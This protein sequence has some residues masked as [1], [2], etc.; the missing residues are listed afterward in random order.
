[1][2]HFECD[3]TEGAHEN[4]MRRL[5]NTNLDQ[6]CGYGMDPICD[7]AREKIRIACQAPDAQV[8]FLVGGTQTNMTVIAAA[9]KPYQGV[10]CA[11]SGHINVHETG[12]IESTGHK[13]LALKSENGKI[14]A[15]AVREAV[16]AHYASGSFEHT[17]QPGMVYISHPTEV[18]T[19]YS[20]EELTALSTTCHALGLPLF[21]DGARL[22]YALECGDVTLP[23]LARLCDVFYIGGTK[24]GALFGEAVVITN[25]ALAKDFRY[26]L[27]Q[28]GGM[29]AKGRLLGIQFDEL[30]TDDLYS[31][32]C[33]EAVRKAMRLQKTVKEKGI[34]LWFESPTNQQ[35]VILTPE[36]K[37]KLS[38]QFVLEEWGET[39]DGGQ[40]TRI[41]TSWAT[42]E[43][44]FEALLAAVKAL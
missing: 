22:G 6:T 3:Y 7:S 2:I 18:G 31:R 24:C 8:H 25:P 4:I 23:D 15:A 5:L 33:S 35:F 27:K 26:S 30:F 20:L 28:R 36:Q 21:V 17:V 40:I 14:S 38:E 29:L 41:C 9:L 42:T 10:L 34:P 1:M 44:N 37:A 19:L 13:A 16:E 12:A 32:I 39:E 11:D 43:E